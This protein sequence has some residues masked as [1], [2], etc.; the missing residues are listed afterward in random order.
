M[1]I[2]TNPLIDS[3]SKLVNDIINLHDDISYKL[4]YYSHQFA[5]DEIQ[6]LK[7]LRDN[8]SLAIRG[9]QCATS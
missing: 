5:Y 6:R 9:I 4:T 1:D 3:K 8:L 2:T 7:T